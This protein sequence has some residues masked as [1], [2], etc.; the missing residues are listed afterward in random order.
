MTMAENGKG[1]AL[2]GARTSGIIVAGRFDVSDYI[3]KKPL[4]SSI[5]AGLA[6]VYAPAIAI[7]V[8]GGVR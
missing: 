7:L 1:R 8:I 3:A 4:S 2:A 5:L 6:L